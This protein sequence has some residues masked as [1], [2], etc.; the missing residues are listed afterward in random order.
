MREAFESVVLGACRM[1]VAP[2]YPG[3]SFR[4]LV[5]ACRRTV[6]DQPWPSHRIGAFDYYSY[7]ASG[8]QPEPQPESSGNRSRIPPH[9]RVALGGDDSGSGE[10][11]VIFL[12]NNVETG[13]F[14]RWFEQRGWRVMTASDNWS[15]ADLVADGVADWVVI[16][17]SSIVLLGASPEFAQCPGIITVVNDNITEVIRAK[18]LG[19][20]FI[21]TRPID[22]ENPMGY[23]T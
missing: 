20:D 11:V 22:S 7:M 2:D 8:S 4:G 15:F 14:V 6:S 19:A 18:R 3:G 13:Y 5:D 10:S 9:L 16:G 12:K 21:V 17:S 1:R 23:A